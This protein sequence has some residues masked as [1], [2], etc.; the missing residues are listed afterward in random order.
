MSPHTSLSLALVHD[1]YIYI[2][3]HIYSGKYETH[4]LALVYVQ[5]V[6]HLQC[7]C[8]KHVG[9]HMQQSHTIPRSLK[10]VTFLHDR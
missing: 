7:T 9:L 3:T 6:V 5:F 8:G 1:I 10:A 4:V 2:Y